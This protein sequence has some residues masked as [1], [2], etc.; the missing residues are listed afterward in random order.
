MS[1]ITPSSIAAAFSATVYL[2]N[3]TKVKAIEKLEG[4][5][6]QENEDEICPTCKN[7]TRPNILVR[8]GL[9]PDSLKDILVLPVTRKRKAPAEACVVAPPMSTTSTE[10]E[11]SI[12]SS[13]STSVNSSINT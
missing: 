4:A 2:L 6:E 10:T 5:D 9:V 13:S 1:K 3:K 8:M 7:S 12:Q 11:T